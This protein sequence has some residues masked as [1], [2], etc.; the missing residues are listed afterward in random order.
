MARERVQ[1]TQSETHLIERVQ[2]G[3]AEAFAPL[4]EAHV[5]LVRRFARSRAGCPELAEDL[6]SE[7]FLRAF[8]RIES[9]T[10]GS[11]EAWL[12]SIA[13]NLYVDHVKSAATR[14]EIPVDK[15]YI[16]E[17]APGPEPILVA[18]WDR[19]RV[20]EALLDVRGA[21]DELSDDQSECLQLRFLQGRSIADTADAMSRSQ[22]AVKVL[23]NRA[24]RSLRE[25]LPFAVAQPGPETT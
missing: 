8:R 9:F 20:A 18:Q 17:M 5:G 11:F 6:V 23:Q 22:G 1:V 4:Y 14:L 7:T 12:T 3:E 15:V 10:G 13:R 2:A 24:V 16:S 19:A 21:I 25:R